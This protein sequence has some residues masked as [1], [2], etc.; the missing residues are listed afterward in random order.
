MTILIGTDVPEAH[1]K[2]EERRG[3]KKETYAVRT[4]LGW[5]LAGPMGNVS[6]NEVSSFFVQSEDD[7]LTEKVNRMFQMDFSEAAYCKES[8]MSLEDKKALAIME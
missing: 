3:R 4:P 1:W 6:T 5:S 8:K 7:V 2:L